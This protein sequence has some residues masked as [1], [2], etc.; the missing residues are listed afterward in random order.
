MAGEV[1]ESGRVI[2]HATQPCPPFRYRLKATAW[3]RRETADSYRVAAKGDGGLQHQR[4]FD[5]RGGC[6][7][8]QIS[9]PS[10]DL[11][12]QL[13]EL[14][15]ETL[16]GQGWDSQNLF[17]LPDSDLMAERLTACLARSVQHRELE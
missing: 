6:G 13:D 4:S 15:R 17:H 12:F 11:G 16:E 1:S 9:H 8:D 10:L 7:L 5:M 2:R 3:L 14:A